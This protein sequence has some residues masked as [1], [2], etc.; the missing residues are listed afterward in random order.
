[1]NALLDTCALIRL[2]EGNLPK[3]VQRCLLDV[4]EAIIPAVVVWEIAIKAKSG[5]LALPSAPLPWVEALGRRHGL[6]IE[7][8]AP[9]VSLLCAAAAL[10]SIHRD[11]F[12]RVLVATALELKL[13]I[14]TSDRTI[15]SYPGVK[16]VW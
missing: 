6:R 1:M 5:K 16:V 7:R 13:M 8:R 12:D 4:Q 14:L 9:D 3:L 15:P 10:P 2:A 11:P